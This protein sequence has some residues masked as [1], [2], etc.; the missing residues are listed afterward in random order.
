MGGF[1][2]NLGV[3]YVWPLVFSVTMISSL[4]MYVLYLRENKK[5]KVTLKL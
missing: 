5:H 3:K 1:I 4:T 2:E